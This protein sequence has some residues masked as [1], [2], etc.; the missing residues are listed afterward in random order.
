VRATLGI[1][2]AI[3]VADFRN[4]ERLCEELDGSGATCVHVDVMDGSASNEITFGPRI[5]QTICTLLHT[6]TELH[7]TVAC[8]W[9]VLQHFAS[10]ANSRFI[11]PAERLSMTEFSQRRALSSRLLGVSIPPTMAIDEALTWS[12]VVDKI[13]I[14]GT[15]PE[16]GGP[17]PALESRVLGLSSGL[18]AAGRRQSVTLQVDGSVKADNVGRIA[19]CGADE[20]VVGSAIFSAAG[21]IADTVAT[22]AELARK[23][24]T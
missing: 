9:D 16:G 17:D 12:S 14:L 20:V 10:I 21:T 22:F 2:P 24:C 23:A 4:L 7:F 18:L 1:C 5:A 3:M 11:L 13:T 19:L 6:P 15:R 8:P